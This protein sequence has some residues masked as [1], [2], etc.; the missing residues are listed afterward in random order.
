[1]DRHV[2]DSLLGLLCDDIEQQVVSDILQLVDV[3][4]A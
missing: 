2:V 1:M 3:D 4:L